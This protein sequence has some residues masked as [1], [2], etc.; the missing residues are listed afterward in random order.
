MTEQQT[1]APSWDVRQLRSGRNW[2]GFLTLDNLDAVADRIRN[3]IGD[4]QSYVWM[5]SNE[6]LG[7]YLPSVRTGQVADKIT[8][9]R[10][11]ADGTL[12]GDITVHDSHGL[13]WITTEAADQA[14]ARGHTPA[15]AAYLE[16]KHDHIVIDHKVPAGHRV[17][18]VVAVERGA[19]D[20]AA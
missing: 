19:E 2:S 15:D 4:Q 10:D 14:A 11:D 9:K 18:W 7:D 5:A 12:I 13:W 16:V 3:L 20:G 17:Y 6:G 8:V 1:T